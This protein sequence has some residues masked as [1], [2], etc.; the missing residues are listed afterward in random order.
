MAGISK[1]SYDAALRNQVALERIKAS[2]AKN[3][4]PYLKEIDRYIR[5]R[6]ALSELTTYN[7]ER[8]TK[9]L[10]AIESTIDKQLKLFAT[11]SREELLELARIQAV[12]ESASLDRAINNPDFESTIPAKSQITAAVTQ[13]PLSIRGAGGGLT[14][15]QTYTSYTA[16]QKK[17]ILGA[18]KQGVFEGQTN[19]EII[20]T[21]RGT[22]SRKFKDGVLGLSYR[23]AETVVRTGIQHV[24]SASRALTFSENGVKQYQWKSVLDSRTSVYCQ[25]LSN[26]IFNVGEGPVPPIHWNCRSTIVPVL[27][28]KYDFLDEG[29]TQASTF[30][31]VPADQTYYDWLSTQ[32]AEF[33]DFAIGPKWGKEFRNGGLTSDQFQKFRL[34]KNFKPITLDEMQQK[35]EAFLSG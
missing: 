22:A 9:L 13:S 15:A 31:P 20:R 12:F 35:T 8:L 26:E 17:N 14:I 10:R 25:G 33:Q 7:R 21:I 2:A 1:Q 30:G 27:P 29:A 16:T 3:I 5:Q 23:Q 24:S 18:I 6:L 11:D 19:N 4:A 28:A 32:S 34:D